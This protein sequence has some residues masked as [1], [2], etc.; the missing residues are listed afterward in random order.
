M[1]LFIVNPTAGNGKYKDVTIGNIERFMQ[2]YGED[3]E[4]YVTSGPM[5]AAEKV[6]REA[7]KGHPLR[8]Y[9]CGGDGTLSECVHG[10]AG[11]RN[12]AVTHYPCGTGNDFVKTFGSDI[13]LFSQLPELVEGNIMPLDIIDV[14][15][16]KGIDI[17]SV[18][19]DA[20]VGVGA[21]KYKNIPVLG[22]KSAYIVSLLV[23]LCKGIT[24]KMTITPENEESVSGSFTL[25][26]VCNG[27]FYGGGFN[28]TKTAMPNDGLLDILVI[29]GVSIFTVAR[30]IGKYAT[31]EYA[32][33]PQYIKY[34]SGKKITVE[35]EKEFL[36]NVDGEGLYTKKAVFK[37]VPSG[38][39]F[40]FPK[41]SKFYAEEQVK[42]R[43]SGV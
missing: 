17:C 14:N 42:R 5:D 23:N 12:A 31:G 6:K 1:H 10:A 26:S 20:R 4:V 32:K 30:L 7:I 22:H 18:G 16:R 8:V 38:V 19:I 27:R 15:G 24:Q 29:K 43:L 11:F 9:A 41:H 37:L 25:V 2:E 3:Y 39:N 13:E 28:P 40:I 21:D 35:A 34:I 36:V 33:F